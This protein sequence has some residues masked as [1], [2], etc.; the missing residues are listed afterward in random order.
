MQAVITAAP[1]HV[2]FGLRL[3][4]RSPMH[5]PRGFAVDTIRPAAS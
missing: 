3:D 1:A 5:K 2:Q 4:M